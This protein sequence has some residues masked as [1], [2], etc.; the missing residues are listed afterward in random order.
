MNTK[1]IIKIDIDLLDK[2]YVNLNDKRSM[3][4]PLFN[5]KNERFV[6]TKLEWAFSIGST[7]KE[8]CNYAGI[9][10]DSLYRY[11]NGR[12]YKCRL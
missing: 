10:T 12:T 7:V 3:G 9:S 1:E 8:A 4:R 5:G 2:E 11:G 6:V